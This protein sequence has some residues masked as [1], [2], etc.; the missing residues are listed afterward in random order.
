MDNVYS[1][2]YGI[3]VTV[4]ASWFLFDRFGAFGCQILDC[5]LKKMQLVTAVSRAV[6]E[7]LACVA[8]CQSRIFERFYFILRKKSSVNSNMSLACK[9]ERMTRQLHGLIF[10]TEK[11]SHYYLDI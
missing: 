2:Q 4:C 6:T 11:F 3:T 1:L 9:S 5:A 10:G 8:F 7:A